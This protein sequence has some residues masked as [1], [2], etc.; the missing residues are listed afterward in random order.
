[1][2]DDDLESADA[3]PLDLTPRDVAPRRRASGSRRWGGL[4]VLGVVVA[5]L[6][7]VLFQGLTNAT[8]YFYNVDEAV[9]KRSDLGTSR[10]RI[11]GNVIP[12]SV[13][14]E[15]QRMEF[16]LK[17]R[18]AVV[19]VVHTGDVPSLFKPAIPVVLEGAFQGDT[20]H[21]DRML[22]KHDETYDEEH[23]SRTREAEQDARS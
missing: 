19:H 23:K 8:V 13:D 22:L 11:Q 16:D 5:G 7:F 4:I 10:F 9:A 2:I 15:G 18:D 12:S 14:D 20:Y 17:Y 21:S 6:G 3:S 1:V